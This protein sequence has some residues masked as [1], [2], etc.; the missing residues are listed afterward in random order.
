VRREKGKGKGGK[1]EDKR[2]NGEVK[3]EKGEG[4]RKNKGGEAEGSNGDKREGR[5]RRR[6]KKNG[7]L[8]NIFRIFFSNIDRFPHFI[9]CPPPPPNGFPLYFFPAKPVGPGRPPP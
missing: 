2:E 8:R 6:E 1:R 9:K 4:R 3:T 7:I 5:R